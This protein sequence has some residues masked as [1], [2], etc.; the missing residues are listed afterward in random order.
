MTE[1]R[2]E[3]SLEEAAKL[4]RAGNINMSDIQ[5]EGICTIIDKDGNV[6]GQMRVCS[7]EE[8]EA[9]AAAA[10]STL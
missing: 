4:Q 1:E 8:A 7:V 6:K 10:V 9:E 5:V 2:R 3:V